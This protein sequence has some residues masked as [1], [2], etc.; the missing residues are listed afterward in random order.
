[1]LT[2]ARFAELTGRPP[3][4]GQREAVEAILE[5]VAAEGGGGSVLVEAPTGSGKT[6]IAAASILELLARGS[7]GKAVLVAHTK[8][9][10]R[11]HEED[12][13]RCLSGMAEPPT[14][15]VLYGKRNYA[16]RHLA[17]RERERLERAKAP[18]GDPMLALCRRILEH[19]AGSVPTLDSSLTALLEE[20]DW[21]RVCC[22]RCRRA[23]RC[24]AEGGSMGRCPD[25]EHT[26]AVER[27]R[28]ADIVLV[29]QSLLWVVSQFHR[30]PEPTPSLPEERRPP[31]RRRGN[32]GEALLLP[33]AEEEEEEDW[34]DYLGVVGRSALLVVDEAHELEPMVRERQGWRLSLDAIVS[35]VEDRVERGL[36]ND[37]A[38]LRRW[39][40]REAPALRRGCAGLLALCRG[41]GEVASQCH[42]EWSPEVKEALRGY[43]AAVKGCVDVLLADDGD[44]LAALRPHLKAV[45]DGEEDAFLRPEEAARDPR[46]ALFPGE[47]R[48]RGVVASMELTPGELLARARLDPQGIPD[49]SAYSL[50]VDDGEACLQSQALTVAASLREN[51]WANPLWGLRGSVCLSATLTTAGGGFG[52]FEKRTGLAGAAA[53]FRAPCLFDYPRQM[54]LAISREEHHRSPGIGDLVPRIDASAG[55]CLLLFTSRRRWG[56]VAEA[57]ERHYGGARVLRAEEDVEAVTA[58]LRRDPLAIVCGLRR[59]WTG[60]DV[61]TLGLVV[62][63]QVPFE[64]DFWPRKR[65]MAL[66]GMAELWDDGYKERS[67]AK[68]VQGVGRLIRNAE[69]TGRQAYIRDRRARRP[70]AVRALRGAFPGIPI[71]F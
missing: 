2:E 10:Q 41:G 19:P 51:L 43:H 68:L 38:L 36:H 12:L 59:Y 54:E 67:H 44:Y 13:R 50:F 62:V 15:A 52:A 57:L 65:L 53:R 5:G 24:R 66:L 47:A 14:M 8:G 46:G 31:Q 26:V 42:L 9:L 61:A 16:C 56:L 27:A 32:D 34:R 33:P 17:L 64:A 35:G 28:R 22:Q 3:R 7:I 40:A 58:R 6:L 70:V 1:M 29:N 48:L 39:R 69:S 49:A 21:R 63:D 60:L 30:C 18:E 11:Q 4:R 20:E 25:C 45:A 37:A 55:A 71:A 23:E